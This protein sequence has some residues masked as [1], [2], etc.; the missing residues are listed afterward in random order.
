MSEKTTPPTPREVC[1]SAGDVA[2][3]KPPRLAIA[4]NLNLHFMPLSPGPQKTAVFRL[5]T[6]GL[7]CQA[8]VAFG[9]FVKL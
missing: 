6:D 7:G 8:A 9:V 4:R 1:A 3:A 2:N 5:F